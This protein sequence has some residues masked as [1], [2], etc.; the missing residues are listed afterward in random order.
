MLTIKREH[1]DVVA[2]TDVR[3]VSERLAARQNERQPEVMKKKSR[4]NQ[5]VSSWSPWTPKTFMMRPA[6]WT[7]LS[8]S[9][10][11]CVRCRG[12]SFWTRH[13]SAGFLGSSSYLIQRQNPV[14]S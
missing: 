12:A 14:V 10:K 6:S 1:A 5:A 3:P 8:T 11:A 9:E 4:D 2:V 13:R 7:V